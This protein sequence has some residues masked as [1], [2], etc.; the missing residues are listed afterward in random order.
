MIGLHHYL[1]GH[2]FE[3]IHGDTEGQGRLS[4]CGPQGHKELNMTE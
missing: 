2:E 3:Q 4:C 1:S